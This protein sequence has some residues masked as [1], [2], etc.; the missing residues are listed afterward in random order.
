MK[1]TQTHSNNKIPVKHI[2]CRKEKNDHE[3]YILHKHLVTQYI[4]SLQIEK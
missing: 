3:I 4:S 1:H 2:V